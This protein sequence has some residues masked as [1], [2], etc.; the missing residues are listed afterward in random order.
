MVEF[1]FKVEPPCVA[2]ADIQLAVILAQTPK[3]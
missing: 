3:C 2:L 1:S